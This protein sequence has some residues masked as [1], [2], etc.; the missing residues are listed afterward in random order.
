MINIKMEPDGVRP[1][2]IVYIE[3]I[4]LKNICLVCNVPSYYRHER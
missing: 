2:Q 1:Q 3:I 4:F